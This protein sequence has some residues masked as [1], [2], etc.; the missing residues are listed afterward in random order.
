MEDYFPS[1][2]RLTEQIYNFLPKTNLLQGDKNN[3]SV[4]KNRLYEGW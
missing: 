2:I 1:N 3:G 4:R